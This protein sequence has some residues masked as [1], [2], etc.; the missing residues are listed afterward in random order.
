M[1]YILLTTFFLILQSLLILSTNINIFPEIFFLSWLTN[2]GLTPF[3]DFF[4]NHGF[5]LKYLLS[6]FTFDKSLSSFKVVYFIL[7]TLNLIFFLLIIRKIKSK[8]GFFLGGLTY[9]LVIFFLS[10]NDFWFETVIATFYL[11]IY[12]I[13]ISKKTKYSS[14][15]LGILAA[16]VSFIKPQSGVVILIIFIMTKNFMP[17]LTFF[18]TET[19]AFIFF[20]L[21]GGLVALIDNLFFYNLYLAKYYR[22]SYFSDGKFIITSL[23]IVSAAIIL[24]IFNKKLKAIYPQ[25]FF[26]ILGLLHLV[27]GYTRIRLVPIATFSI[28]LVADTF[29]YIKNKHKIIL[30]VI[31][32]IYTLIMLFKVYQ[33]RV[34][35]N[36]KR[37]PYIEVK[38]NQDFLLNRIPQ[39]YFP[40]KYP[41]TEK[42]YLN[43]SNNLFFSFFDKTNPFLNDLKNKFKR[44]FN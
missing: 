20:A 37:I 35:L 8:L 36:Q 6:P 40:V 1:F 38:K 18:L 12:L 27:S 31:L 26:I 4:D 5:L 23:L 24:V 34:F 10:Q 15:V 22:P 16:L 14:Y 39:T 42:Y 28:I 11:L 3:K 2:R 25:L 9:V 19:A 44:C 13:L 32:G 30:S 17:L 29:A 43:C 21:K 7:Q 33:H 41:L